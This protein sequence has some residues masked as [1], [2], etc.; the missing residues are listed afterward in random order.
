MEKPL[1]SIG[2]LT[3]NQE[4]YIADALEG[5]LSQE[6][7]RMELL[8]LDDASEDKTVT[9]IEQY[10]K[11][12]EEKFERVLITI[13]KENTGNIPYNCN[14]M[15]RESGGDFYF[16]AAGDDVV[17]PSGV[18]MLC[19]ALQEHPEC[20]VV[21]ANMIEVPDTYAFGDEFDFGAVVW[22]RR[23]EGI[24]EN[25]LFQRLMNGNCI[26]APT[27]MLRRAVF[28]KCGY[29][30][31]SIAYEDYE[32]WI[33]L[34]RTE[35]FYFTAAPVMLHR[36]A[37]ISVTNFDGEKAHN[38]L[39]VAIN[40]DFL[41]KKKYIEYLKKNEQIVCW[42]SYYSYYYKFCT[43]CQFQDGL[44]W[45]QE[46]MKELGIEVSEAQ[47][48]YKE[49]YEKQK[50]DTEVLKEWLAIKSVPKALGDYL[51]DKGTYH[52][53]IYGYVRLGTVLQRELLNDGI[54][55]DYVIDRM[56]TMLECPYTVYT[57]EDDLPQTD[58]IIVVPPGLC[59]V[60]KPTL[61]QKV[62]AAIFDLSR[63][64]GEVREENE[65]AGRL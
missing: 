43:Q 10:R 20:T 14:C 56:G 6:Y 49:M 30:D 46:K 50:Q 40:A 36:L 15:M 5:L 17:L 1:V 63:M 53:A 12:L 52:V 37:A 32:Y 62:D 2:L 45:L 22:K 39:R 13:N 38:K 24:E 61:A 11:R 9:V 29:H 33:R 19:E 57:I 58:A 41:V 60:V 51:R 31:E 26:A 35:K 48:S 44:K 59:D 27:V 42:K 28:D 18:R 3:Y 8:I 64:I 25:N 16:E 21:H 4:K 34:S 23:K 54:D 65:S 7:E 55:V 47:I